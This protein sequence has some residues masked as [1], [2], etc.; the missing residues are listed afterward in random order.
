[1]ALKLFDDA[2]PRAPRRVTLV[3][4]AGEIARALVGIDRIAVEGEVYRPRVSRG[5][6]TFFTLRDRAAQLEVVVPSS[7][8]RRSRAADGERVCVTGKL[9]WANEQGRLQLVAEE[10][11]PVGAGAIA[12][13]IA[14]TRRQLEAEGLLGG[15][16][17]PLPLLPSAIGVVCGADAAVRRDI[18]SVVAARF[19]G[20]PVVFEETTV[21]GPGVSLSIVEAMRAVSAVPSVEVVILAR[22]GGDGPSLLPWSTEEVCRAVA[23]CPIPVVSAIGHESDHPLCDEVADLRCGTPSIAAAAVVPH[24]G[25]LSA[26]VDGSLLSAEAALLARFGE[27]G[28]RLAAIDPGRSLEGGVERAAS[29]LA[30]GA[31]RLGDCHPSRE[32][33]ACRHRLDG[34][35]WRR[36]LGEILGRAQGRLS[37]DGRHLEALSPRRTLERG[38]A[39]VVGPGGAVLRR[40]AEVSPGDSIEVELADGGLSASVTEARS[41]TEMRSGRTQVRSSG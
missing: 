3:R 15:R 8:A 19:A 13:L 32:L 23:A 9:Q 12:A 36:P 30:R 40:A 29:R 7:A 11:L 38:Y 18:E 6:W 21:S 4:L 26:R 1:M 5:G 16:R 14:E 34:A 2:D 37:A 41:A 33:Q 27:A 24:R 28:R 17:R 39:V 22:G 35:D 20:Y 31:Q 25:E 10:V